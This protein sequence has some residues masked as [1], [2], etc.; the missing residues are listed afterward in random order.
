MP[1]VNNVKT[2]SSEKIWSKG[3]I[4]IWKITLDVDGKSF[5]AKTYSGKIAE[6]GWSGDVETYEKPNRSGGADT[7]VRQPQTEG[8][9]QASSSASAP[10]AKPASSGSNP[11]TMFLSYAKDIAVAFITLEGKVDHEQFSQ[12]IDEIIQGGHRLMESEQEKAEAK[13]LADTVDEVF[14]DDD[15]AQEL[16]L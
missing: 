16:P 15:G 13:N 5:F 7:F 14:G 4:S 10:S 1:T 11:Y 6:M 12:V 3:E 8:Y 9:Q 2:L